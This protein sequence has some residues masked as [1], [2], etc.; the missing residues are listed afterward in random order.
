MATTSY[1]NKKLSYKMDI[2]KRVL[3]LF[4][5]KS[6]VT[7]TSKKWMATKYKTCG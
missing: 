4:S 7:N 5:R 1:I 3:A 6:T 2:K